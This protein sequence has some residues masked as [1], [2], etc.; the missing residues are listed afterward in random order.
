VTELTGKDG[1][2][3]QTQAVPSP[4]PPLEVATAIEALVRKAEARLNITPG[5]RASVAQRVEQI[6][7]HTT[8]RGEPMSSEMYRALHVAAKAAKAAKEAAGE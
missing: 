2:P 3:I 4:M 5:K 7:A 8:G 6:V 1:G